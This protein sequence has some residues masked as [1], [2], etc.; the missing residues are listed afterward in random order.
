MSKIELWIEDV[1]VDNATA[2]LWIYGKTKDGQKLQIPLTYQE[3]IGK[4]ISESE[5]PRDIL[6][7]MTEYANCLKSRTIPIILDRPDSH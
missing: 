5:Q 6:A 1:A 3:H 7:F 4:L 2:T